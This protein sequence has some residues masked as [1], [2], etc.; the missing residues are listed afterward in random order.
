MSRRFETTHWSVI[1]DV[2]DSDSLR[3]R[4]ALEYLANAYWY[5][6][7]NFIRRRGHTDDQARDL[8]QEFFVQLLDREVIERADPDLGRFRSF[9]L[10]SAKNFLSNERAWSQAAK[11]SPGDEILSLDDED[12][13]VRYQKDVSNEDTPE[14]TFER[15]WAETVVQRALSRMEEEQTSR[16]DAE[17]YRALRDWVVGSPE[18]VPHQELAV[19]LGVGQSAV[20]VA[21]HR[22]R[23]RLGVVLRDEIASTV[24]HPDQIEDELQ[25]LLQIVASQ[26]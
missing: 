19:R 22:L 6:L 9:I 18:A 5:P 25:Y 2:G 17:R 13:A 26:S 12:T 15:R 7:Y 21:I 4:L 3:S 23:K 10:A 16:G 11:R 14:Q 8:T 24:T 1:L 20:R